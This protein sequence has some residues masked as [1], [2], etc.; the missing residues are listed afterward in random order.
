MQLERY[1]GT[2][3]KIIN[4]YLHSQPKKLDKV[5]CYAFVI[6]NVPQVAAMLS[7]MF[8][9]MYLKIGRVVLVSQRDAQ[10]LGVFGTT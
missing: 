6:W 1:S 9:N 8:A 10:L 5:L 4:K 3:H 7:S 2:L